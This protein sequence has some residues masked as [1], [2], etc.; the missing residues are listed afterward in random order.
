MIIIKQLEIVYY[1]L[2]IA[3][4][5]AVPIRGIYRWYRRVDVA[6]SNHVPHIYAILER[7]CE[8]MGIPYIDLKGEG[9]VETHK[10]S[11]KGRS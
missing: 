3:A 9:N 1:A 8:H 2:G 10:A 11:D 7:M 4:V 5:I 6:V